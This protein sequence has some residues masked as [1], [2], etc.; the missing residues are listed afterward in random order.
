MRA[1]PLPLTL[2]GAFLTHSRFD[3]AQMRIT[4][5]ERLGIELPASIQRSVAK[6]QAE[7]LAGRLC[8]REALAGLGIRDWVVA[9]NEDRAPVWP[10]G[11]C[12]AITHG[13]GWAAAVVARKTDYRGLG[14][15]VE[16]LLEHERAERLHTQI[17]TAQEICRLRQAPVEQARLIVTLSF[18]LKESLFKALYPLVLE[19][20]YFEHAEIVEWHPDG[21]ARLRLLTD[22]STEWH[23]GCEFDAQFSLENQRLL[24][25]VWIR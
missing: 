15:D 6:R 24:S 7:F 4:E 25:L 18:S 10:P 5:F 23:Y 3:P 17:L 13:S 8:A 12:G 21:R 22:L 16:Q 14:L 20:F 1:W 11:L 9:I 19:R 2:P